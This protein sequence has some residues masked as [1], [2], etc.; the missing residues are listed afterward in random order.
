MGGVYGSAVDDDAFFSVGESV[1]VVF[2]SR[3]ENGPVMFRALVRVF[4]DGVRVASGTTDSDGIFSFTPDEA[5]EYTV[6]ASKD[7]YSDSNAVVITVV[8]GQILAPATTTATTTSTTTS[9]P[10]T[11]TT[12]TTTI[13]RPPETTTT[14]SE[15]PGTTAVA[16]ATTLPV[17]ATTPSAPATT[18]MQ[19]QEE[20][21]SCVIIKL[22]AAGAIVLSA[23]A[24]LLFFALRKRSEGDDEAAKH[25]LK[26]RLGEADARL[27]QKKT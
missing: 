15:L 10:A 18:V 24:I 27:K 19:P 2:R 22:I 4:L 23:S 13:G 7:G 26:T 17:P 21:G 14:T 20:W 5:G 25:T 1:S 16:P 8:D 12:S 11:A 3:G 6:S 9:S